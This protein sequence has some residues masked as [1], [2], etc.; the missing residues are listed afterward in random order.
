M[1]IEKI[2]KTDKRIFNGG[3][4]KGSGRKLGSRELKTIVKEAAALRLTKKIEERI[5]ELAEVLV[6][7]ALTG[8]IPAIKEAFERGLGKVI[9]RRITEHRDQPSFDAEPADTGIQ[10]DKEP[11]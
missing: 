6:D 4:R 9:E 7:K 5:D 11:S 3:A 8:D 1:E 10:E 2:E